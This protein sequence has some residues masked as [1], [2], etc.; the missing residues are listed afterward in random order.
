MKV[1]QIRPRGWSS[2][3][4]RWEKTAPVEK[5]R[6]WAMSPGMDHQAA[7]HG[8][9][10]PRPARI[11]QV[12][13]QQHVA[14]S[15][16]GMLAHRSQG[17]NLQGALMRGGK[18]DR[19]RNSRFVSLEP[20]RCTYTPTVTRLESGKV[21]FRTGRHKVIPGQDAELKKFARHFRA[22]CVA[23]KVLL[24]CMAGAIT[25]KS[26]HRVLRA[27]TQRTAQHILLMLIVSHR[28]DLGKASAG[29]TRS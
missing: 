18:N 15:S 1:V 5:S 4:L 6:C 8:G 7:N 17:N 19:R 2:S 11:L 26:G 21:V 14:A 9:G 20:T 23:S 22:N 24:T 10:F 12:K 13:R 16:R 25:K 28:P 3:I 27:G 29:I